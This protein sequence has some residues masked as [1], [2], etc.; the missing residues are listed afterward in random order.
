[1][2]NRQL[3]R[4][5]F[6][7]HYKIHTSRDKTAPAALQP[8]FFHSTNQ[9]NRF[10]NNLIAPSGFWKSIH[11]AESI[12]AEAI[13]D[14][15]HLIREIAA[16]FSRGKIKAYK[17]SSYSYTDHPPEKRAVTDNEKNKHIFTSASTLLISSPREVLT[18]T[19]K[20]EA[21]QY[22]T[23]LSPNRVSLQ[24][25]VKELELPRTELD[26]EYG[27][28]IELVATGLASGSIVVFLDRYTTPPASTGDTDAALHGDKDAGKGPEKPECTFDSMTLQCSHYPKDRSFQLDVIKDK[29]NLNGV[30][31][32]LQVI[33][34][35]GDPDKIKVEFSG[36]CG[37]GDENCPS[38]NIDSDT[39]TE[40]SNKS[41]YE[42]ESF[43]KEKLHEVNSFTD[44]LKYC[45]VPDIS[46]LDY[47]VY[48]VSKSGCNGSEGHVAKIHSF[49]TFKWGG[50]VTFGYAQKD[51][52]QEKNATNLKDPGEWQ[53][54]AKL[55]GE[56][57]QQRFEFKSANK[58]ETDDY[59]P[60]LKNRIT[61]LI[62]KI[63]EMA[64]QTDNLGQ[65]V[66]KLVGLKPGDGK[67]LLKFKATWPKISLNGNLE[68]KEAV[69]D[70]DV[71][72]GGEVS[73]SMTPL[74]GAEVRTDILSWI[75]RGFGPQAMFLEEL[76]ERVKDKAEIAVDI[77]LN[78]QIEADLK[79]TKVA[80]DKWLNFGGNK[81]GEATLGLFLGLEARAK[82]EVNVFFVKVTVGVELQV[83][84]NTSKGASEGV[85][86]IGTL[87]ATTNK[88]YPAIG[89][90]FTFTGVAIYFSYYAEIG[91]KE[92]TSD[93][94]QNQNIG[95]RQI[96]SDDDDEQPSKELS[97]KEQKLRKLDS[98]LDAWEFPEKPDAGNGRRLK[99]VEL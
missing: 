31:K 83:K 89:G 53:L 23:K 9:A 36:S 85:G 45:L 96:N 17:I 25:L 26:D 20:T 40:V 77:I 87:Y 91:S 64:D 57:G 24:N 62:E 94:V 46:S 52:S 67:G 44:F 68:L 5:H 35:P 82:A 75:I 27:E 95:Q 3:V 7:Q 50:S 69:N 88:D 11:N 60:S 92:A 72:I 18:F 28:L 38:I 21:T 90:R 79:W 63:D 34:K 42:F 4:D 54:E 61:D 13:H 66:S 74:F 59:F 39:L 76:R 78:G 56:I 1:M 47:Q 8:E 49:P 71:D 81:A 32:A 99:D 93:D 70:F 48:T 16:L 37:C 43:P 98:V 65:D 51:G 12:S 2:F 6:G 55:E 33:A 30:D 10:I 86:I 97:G 84:G 15:A 73:L 19:N 58:N 29:P 80:H 22:L 14:E 41:P